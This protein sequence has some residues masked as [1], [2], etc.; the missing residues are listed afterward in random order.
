MVLFSERF[1]GQVR[2]QVSGKDY[3]GRPSFSFAVTS[4]QRGMMKESKPL[5]GMWHSPVCNRML[6]QPDTFQPHW[7]EAGKAIG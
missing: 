6:F 7:T 3:F 1:T 4:L 5:I 2:L